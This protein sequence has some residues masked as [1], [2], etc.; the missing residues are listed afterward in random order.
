MM[1]KKE[2]REVIE[3]L[4]RVRDAINREIAAL[5]MGGPL[6]E[7]GPAEEIAYPPLDY[8]PDAPHP[9]VLKHQAETFIVGAS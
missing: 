4:E 5:A 1:T 9:D 8:P 7:K 6:Y 2:T 3:A